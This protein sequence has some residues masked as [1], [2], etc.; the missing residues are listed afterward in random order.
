VRSRAALATVLAASVAAVTAAPR[1]DLRADL[2]AILTAPVLARAL[3]AVR[4]DSLTTGATLYQRN[5]DKLVVPAS[6]LKLF[7]L[8]VA[9]E[10]LGWDHRFETRLE[11]AGAIENGVLT[12]DL[13]VTGHG[14]PS[15]V[16]PDLGLAPL[17]LEW[18][19]A[20]RAAGI[21]RV[22]GRLI[23][24]DN[25][26]DDAGLGAG[27]AWDYLALNYA[28]PAG[29][30][31]FNDNVATIRIQP[32]AQEGEPA[33]IDIAP[34]GARFTIENL[35]RTSAPGVPAVVRVGR[36]PGAT[37]LTVAGTVPAG[38]APITRV[39]TVENPTAYFVEAMRL[40]LEHR[41]IV[42]SG[43]AWDVDDVASPIASAPRVLIA[44]R[45]SAPLSSLGAQMLKVSQNFYGEML[46]KSIGRVNGQ[47][48]TAETGRQ[49]V[50]STLE[51]WGI[52][53]ESI[54]MYDG[55]G[56]SRYNYATTDAIVTLLTRVWRDERLRG[57]FAAAL[58]VGA[59]DG[60]LEAR[61]KN[62]ELARRVQAKTG[63]INNMRA[64][65]GYLETRSGERLV[66]SF[67]ANHFTARAA[68]IDAV[69]EQMLLRLMRGAGG[70]APRADHATYFPPFRLSVR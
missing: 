7:T 56:L 39:T 8:A 5:S 67:V 42:V 21:L 52:D 25:A 49:A 4:V 22:S 23:G 55:S 43:G 48:G 54:V 28:A 1:Q 51:G 35:L 26:F 14:D 50:R 29:A 36:L 17:F 57:P 47:P 20:L 10:R 45:Q 13:I 30:L 3:V 66:F 46:L 70:P 53:R 65:S 61:M 62:T 6:N 16:S 12:G 34:A 11:A 15:I 31:S 27:W 63:T 59:H 24:D 60:T 69:A 44:H 68:E 41:G 18:A 38:A 19:D 32:G 40:A 33:R 37:R 64:L 9:A 58:P 2:D